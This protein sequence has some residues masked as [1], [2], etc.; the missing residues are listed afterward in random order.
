[1]FVFRTTATWKRDGTFRYGNLVDEL[2][3]LEDTAIRNR[4]TDN[5]R[6]EE[7]EEDEIEEDEEEEEENEGSG[8]NPAVNGRPSKHPKKKRPKGKRPKGKRP[9]QRRPNKRLFIGW[10]GSKDD[11]HSLTNDMIYDRMIH[12]DRR[13][14]DRFIEDESM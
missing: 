6:G 1:M 12:N 7:D 14:E 3:D 4:D 9:R 13:V 11:P 10:D 8:E 5:N 2:A